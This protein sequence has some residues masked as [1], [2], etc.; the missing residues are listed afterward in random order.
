MLNVQY[1]MHED[2]MTW[3]SN[4]L[5]GGKVTAHVSNAQ[6]RLSDLEASLLLKINSITA[7]NLL[8]SSGFLL[9]LQK[10]LRPRL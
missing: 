1:R 8:K 4:E 6:H 7:S 3:S 10:S 5:Y 2:I 9:S